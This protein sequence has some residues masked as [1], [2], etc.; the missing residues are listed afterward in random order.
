M[1]RSNFFVALMTPPRGGRGILNFPRGD[2]APKGIAHDLLL[3]S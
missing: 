2:I 1:I 3:V